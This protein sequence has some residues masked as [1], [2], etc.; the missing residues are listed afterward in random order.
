MANAQA[1]T[2]SSAGDAAAGTVG[3][4]E[5]K[6]GGRP[7]GSTRERI[8]DVALDLFTERG[9]GDTSLREVADELGFTKAALY[10]HFEKKEDI[11]LALHLRLHAI[12]ESALA[13]LA[14]IGQEATVEDWRAVIDEFL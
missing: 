5:R 11:L 12:G 10:Y 2:A 7:R 8:L 1:S 6:R 13:Q 4:G 14:D 9:Y 3:I